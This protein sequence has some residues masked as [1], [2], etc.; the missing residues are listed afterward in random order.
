MSCSVVVSAAIAG[1]VVAVGATEGLGLAL[2]GADAAGLDAAGLALAAAD[3][4]AAE[5]TA[6]AGF[7]ATLDGAA[8][9]AV[10]AGAAAPPQPASIR[11]V[12]D[13]V[14]RADEIFTILSSS[15]VFRLYVCEAHFL[16]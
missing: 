13:A 15:D 5:L 14:P 12:M 11:S 6:E 4:G 7:G 9:G 8:A 3:D 16:K 2:A 1:K 10:D